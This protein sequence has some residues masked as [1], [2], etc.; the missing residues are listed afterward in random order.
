MFTLHLIACL[1]CVQLERKRH[2][3][4]DIVVIIFVDYD[5]N[6]EEAIQSALNFNPKFMRSHFNHIFA[7]VTYDAT[8][9]RYRMSVCSAES[10]PFFGPPLPCFG[11]F[12]DPISFRDFL[13][14]KCEQCVCACACVRVCVCVCV[15][16]CV[17]ACCVCV[18]V[19]VFCACVHVCV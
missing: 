1:I 6:P 12:G 19:C 13:L 7:L 17:R 15:C 10:V 5:T 8:T 3:G 11:E 18:C 14:A 16:V 9:D 2:I 4:N